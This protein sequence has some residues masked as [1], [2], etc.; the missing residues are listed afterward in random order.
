MAAAINPFPLPV[1]PRIRTVV[2]PGATCS[3][4]YMA[5]FNACYSDDM[6][7]MVLIMTFLRK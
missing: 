6:V 7:E 3:A 5:Y 4:L 1:S 2:S